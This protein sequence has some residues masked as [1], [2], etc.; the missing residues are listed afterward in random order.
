VAANEIYFIR[1]GQASFGARD[2]DRLSPIGIRQS[3]VLADHLVA[4]GIGFDAVYSG[5][6]RRQQDTAMPLCER[7]GSG[8]PACAAPA[9]MDAFNEYSSE[10]LLVARARGSR[11]TDPISAGALADMH[12]DKKA[13]QVYFA[14]TVHGWLD[15]TFDGQP[16]V[17]SW[18]RF[19]RR[20][21]GGV[22]QIIERHGRG[23]RLAV[24]TSGGP[25]MVVVKTA[26]G[27]TGRSAV[28]VGWQI[29]NASLTCIRYTND[30]FVLSVFNTTTHLLLEKDPALL[31]YR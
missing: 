24:F 9:V 19:C 25:I 28:A 29:M 16:G 2:Y 7:Y 4:Y 31:T 26:L 18:R 13:F 21:N 3:Q 11:Q 30:R 8:H 14:E 20:V 12:K 22:Q 23:K 5:R 10:A 1:H 15:G 17:E 27:L 6:M